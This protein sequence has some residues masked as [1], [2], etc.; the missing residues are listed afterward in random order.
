MIKMIQYRPDSWLEMGEAEFRKVGVGWQAVNKIINPAT[1]PNFLNITIR[2]LSTQVF[3]VFPF[4][5]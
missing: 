1:M 2:L 5:L 3:N 4:L